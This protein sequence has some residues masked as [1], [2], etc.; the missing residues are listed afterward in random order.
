MQLVRRVEPE[1]LDELPADDPAALRSRHD[2]RR[3]NRFMATLMITLHALERASLPAPRRI[4]ELGAGD[5]TLMLRLARKRA[6]QWPA[7]KLSLL[8]RQDIVSRETLTEFRQLGWEAETVIAD[9]FD[10]LAQPVEAP[11][12]LILTNLFIHHFASE[13]LSLLLEGI[14]QHTRVFMACEPRRAPVALASSYLLGFI[15]CNAVTRNDAVLSV[16]AGFNQQELS[17]L[18]PDREHWI[19]REWPAGLFSHGFVAKRAGT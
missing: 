9:V 7:V 16:H 18:W 6:A 3:V 19:L 1:M 4:V 10:W 8:D 11:V 12:D 15:G 13:R 14:A 2:L 5:G 17:A